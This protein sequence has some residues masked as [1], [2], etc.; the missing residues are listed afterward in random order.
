[1]YPMGKNYYC[2]VKREIRERISNEQN[3]RIN[4]VILFYFISL[5]C[6]HTLT[7]IMHQ[8]RTV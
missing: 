8:N 4:K 3:F 2:F 5:D 1:M 7:Q 6:Q